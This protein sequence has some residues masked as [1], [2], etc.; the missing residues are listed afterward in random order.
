M[1]KRKALDV[2]TCLMSGKF[3]LNDKEVDIKEFINNGDTIRSIMYINNFI[4]KYEAIPLNKG[5]LWTSLEDKKLEEG[6]KNQLSYKDLAQK[7]ERTEIA[8]VSRLEKLDLI[9]SRFVRY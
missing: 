5:K 7:L 2:I 4:L 1:E 9:P 6:F 3:M 8:I